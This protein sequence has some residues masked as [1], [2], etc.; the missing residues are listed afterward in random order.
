MAN[1]VALKIRDLQKNFK[2]QKVLRGVNI[3]V[4]QGEIF[5]LLG[6]NGAGKTTLIKIIATLLQSDAGTIEFFGRNLENKPQEIKRQ[7]SL[8]GQFAAVDSLLSVEENLMMMARLMQKTILPVCRML[9][10]ASRIQRRFSRLRT[11]ELLRL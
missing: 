7:I 2:N 1:S 4:Y 8:T 9:S 10:Q 5:S 6:S 11:N 3:D